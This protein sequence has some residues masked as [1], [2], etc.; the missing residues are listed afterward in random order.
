MHCNKSWRLL[1]H[2]CSIMR[3]CYFMLIAIANEKSNIGSSSS[4]KF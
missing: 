2:L 1:P 3:L 4:D